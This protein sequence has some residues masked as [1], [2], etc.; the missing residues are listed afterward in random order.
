MDDYARDIS[1]LENEIFTLSLDDSRGA[2]ALRAEKEEELAELLREQQKAQREETISRTEDA[3]DEQN[4]LYGEMLDKM[5]ET[6]QNWLNNKSAV[7]EV[8]VDTIEQRQTNDLLNRLV[9]YNGEHGDAMMTTVVTAVGDLNNLLSMEEF[10][11]KNIESIIKT[12][13]K[14]INVDQETIKHLGELI[15]SSKTDYEETQ[16]E[17]KSQEIGVHHSGLAVGFTGDGADLKQHEVYRLLT[18]DE[19]VFNRADQLRIAGQ[20]QTLD[21]IKSAF[22][23]L[24][25]GVTPQAI[26][27]NQPVELVISPTINIQG[28]ASTETVKQI[29]QA[30][31]RASNDALTKLNDALRMK[32]VHA[33]AASNARKN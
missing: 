18:D 20:L 15:S 8:V 30:V 3:L 14:G 28:N 6:I 23:D 10:K 4:N 26:T 12:L 11:G 9:A 13:E 33:R 19:L 25:K 31:T 17:T 22:D 1:K 7:L 32:G 5:A 21:T 16:K 29:E 27:S 2:A 24:T